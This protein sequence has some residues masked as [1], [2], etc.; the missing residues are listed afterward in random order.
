MRE[1][2][3]LIARGTTHEGCEDGSCSRRNP[4]TNHPG[5]SGQQCAESVSRVSASVLTTTD[6]GCGTTQR[7]GSTL[8]LQGYGEWCAVHSCTYAD[9]V[10]V[11]TGTNSVQSVRQR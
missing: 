6:H 9:R 11:H 1:S 7:A 2:R 8:H 10:A 4:I 5:V 3:E